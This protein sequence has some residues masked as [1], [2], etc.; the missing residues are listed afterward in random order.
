MDD[1]LEQFL[2][3]ARD[4]IAQANDDLAAL[5]RSADDAGRI[6]GAFRAVHT[7]K[8]SVA[9]FDMAP[10][11]A[12]LHAAEDLLSDAR[13]GRRLLNAASVATLIDCIDQTDRW[14]DAIEQ[15]GRLPADAAKR[16]AVLV[17]S[18]ARASA[19]AGDEPNAETAE[20]PDWLAPLIARQATAIAETGGAL[21]A[22][23]YLPDAECFFRGDD[24]VRI[25]G[26]VPDLIALEIAPARPCPSPDA[27]DPFA[28]NLL[29]HGISAG[30]R[31]DVDLAFRF[32][33]DQ[34]A[35]AAVP[36][37]DDHGLSDM[38][39]AAA[40]HIDSGSATRTLRVD[41]G[42]IDALVE[43]L[44]E[45][46]VAKNALSHI[47]AQA[48]HAAL[49]GPALAAAIRESQGNIERLI[50]V[51]NRDV[52]AVRLVPLAQTFR[53]LPRLVRQIAETLGREVN[54]VISGDEA[55][56]D[57]ATADGLFE[58]LLHLLRNAVDH[59]IE[60]PAARRA[61]GKAER[62]LIQLGAR[63]AGDQVIIDVIDDGAGIDAAKM[64]RT[65]VL[66]GIAG[67]AAAD[68]M[69]DE[70]ALGLIFTPGFSTAEAITDVSGRG[71]G[72]DAVR[73]AIEKLGG[74]VGISSTI[75]AG[76]TFRLILPLTAVMTKVLTVRSG[77]ELFGIPIDRIAETGAVARDRIMDVGGGKAIVH[78]DR[79]VPLLSLASL[80][81]GADAPPQAGKLLF[82]ETGEDMVAVGI[83][84][85]G[86]RLDVMLR[87]M[88]GLLAGTPGVLG[89]TLM[90]D[91]AVLLVLDVAELI[92]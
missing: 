6:D 88:T 35:I 83:D 29:L 74:R 32:V 24:P 80:L 22:F 30:A 56:V 19:A 86:E 15:A 50:A 87:P 2:I 47:A 73:S 5:E 20:A 4:L 57:K 78:R 12:V 90:G 41:A 77:P 69:D 68:A 10:V 79:T 40:A 59:G 65:A 1:L 31:A 8:G 92:G 63:V 39:S 66:R 46:I 67:Q 3:E 43:G 45:L 23:R 28:C 48:E 58:P 70:A 60:T 34:V 26:S 64:R 51:M 44:G 16:A 81:G 91:G 75:G 9:I 36:G 62:G 54:F 21:T 13:S 89:T 42:R 27:I 82:V 25:A 17:T 14:V 72:M 37:R 11:G 61:G 49:A 38:D 84:G 55:E 33:A 18:L 53:R 76:T 85:F 52:M 71:V 7:L